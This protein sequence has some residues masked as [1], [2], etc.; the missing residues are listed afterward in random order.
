MA[1]DSRQPS[2]GPVFVITRQLDVLA[3]FYEEVI[4]LRAT[5]RDPDHHVWYELHGPDF[6]LH[7]PEPEPGVNFT[8]AEDG[9]LVWFEVAEDALAE[10]AEAA[11]RFGAMT[12]G[13]YDGGTR[14]LLYAVDP[15]G[16]A[17]GLYAPKAPS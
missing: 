1:K 5:R 17:I 9:V 6:V 14:T 12:W 13:P 7:V 2:V 3:R 4:G 15:D 16:N 10:A 8:P 11:R